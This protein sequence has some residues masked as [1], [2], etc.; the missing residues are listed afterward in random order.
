MLDSGFHGS[1]AASVEDLLPENVGVP[2][3][4][5]EFAE[6][7]QMQGPHKAVATTVDD[8]IEG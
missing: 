4:L 3:V 1:V 8:V 6:H 5:C 7:L 2:G